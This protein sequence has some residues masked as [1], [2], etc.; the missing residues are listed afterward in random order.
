MAS[1]LTDEHITKIDELL[2]SRRAALAAD[3]AKVA[4][5][6]KEI[7]ALKSSQ[8][9]WKRFVAENKAEIAKLEKWRGL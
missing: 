7:D 9:V 3:E 4:E 1:I 6:Q 2:V 5:Y 8:N